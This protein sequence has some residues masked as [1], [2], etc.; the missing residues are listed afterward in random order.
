MGGFYY[1]TQ[2]M[3][4]ALSVEQGFPC[5][6]GIR[7]LD[8]L[9]HRRGNYCE[10][11]SLFRYVLNALRRSNARRGHAK[12]LCVQLCCCRV[13]L[14]NLTLPARRQLVSEELQQK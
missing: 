4:F 3:V 9:R 10:R 14:M 1:V 7:L 12:L 8:C 6:R 13:M 5:A 2:S 11:S